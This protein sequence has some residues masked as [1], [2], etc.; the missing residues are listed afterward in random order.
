MTPKLTLLIILSCLCYVAKAAMI[1]IDTLPAGSSKRSEADFY[2]LYGRDDS[3]RA[4]INYFFAKRK[5]YTR[6]VV[7]NGALSAASITATS[8]TAGNIN[9]R[10]GEPAA[11][12]GVFL[13]IFAV[14]IILIFTVSLFGNIRNRFFYFSKR[15]LLRTLEGHQLGK[16]MPKRITNDNL[17]LKFVDAERMNK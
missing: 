5:K 16:G 13:I 2:S 15:R 9:Q 8:I 4:L 11:L 7:V 6:K 17:Y 3:T 1:S 10:T 12:A 14:P